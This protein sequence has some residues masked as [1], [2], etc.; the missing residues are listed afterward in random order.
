VLPDTCKILH[1]GSF[2]NKSFTLVSF[3]RDLIADLEA[4]KAVFFADFKDKNS[5]EMPPSVDRALLEKAV[6]KF[7]F[8]MRNEISS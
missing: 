3:N 8:C 4:R 5:I 7:L 2:T 1:K 6:D